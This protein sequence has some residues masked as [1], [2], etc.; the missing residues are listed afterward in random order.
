M[1]KYSDYSVDPSD[2]WKDDIFEREAHG[3]RLASLL[4]SLELPHVISVRADWGSG[5][6]VF[7]RRLAAQ[8]E[9]AGTP[10]VLIDAWRSDYL[11]DPMLAF[12]AALS[13]RSKKYLDANKDEA[14]K[15]KVDEALSAIA[16]YGTQMVVPTVEVLSA[17]LPGSSDLVRQGAT[18]V[19]ELGSK[20]LDWEKSQRDAQEEFREALRNLRAQL[21]GTA[22][23]RAVKRPIVV[24][25]DELDRCRPSYAIRTLERIK[26]FFDVAGVMFV[27]A[28][29]KSN[30]PAAVS[31]VYGIDVDQAE[32]YLRRF[33]DIEYTLPEP[34][35]DAFVSSLSSHFGLKKLAEDLEEELWKQ[36]YL[37]AYENLGEYKRVRRVYRRAADIMEIVAIFPMLAKAWKLTLRDQAQ[38][39]NLIGLVIRSSGSDVQ[40]PQV[41]AYICCLRFHAPS[42]YAD[43]MAGHVDFPRVLGPDK[44]QRVQGIAWLNE[45]TPEGSDLMAFRTLYMSEARSLDQALNEHAS[46]NG[47]NAERAA[48]FRRLQARLDRRSAGV[49]YDYPRSIGTLVKAFDSA[50]LE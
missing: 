31:S 39:F 43:F 5:K 35:T 4:G 25:I 34:S 37:G 36:A 50:E 28:T 49:I 12:I 16:R 11:D 26:H 2:P 6:S 33:I 17:A 44:D 15:K 41:L 40:F 24:I 29:D 23:G 18:L 46:G 14:R 19:K 27:I 30:L 10:T 13:L 20:M 3:K 22:K 42:L 48:G 47:R 45:Y 38:A 21:T 7:L 9:L 8:L 32:R 1:D